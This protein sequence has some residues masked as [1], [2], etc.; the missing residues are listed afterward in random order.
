MTSVEVVGHHRGSHRY[1]RMIVGN[2]RLTDFRAELVYS[3]YVISQL[4]EV[5]VDAHNGS[6]GSAEV[7]AEVEKAVAHLIG[8]S[9]PMSD[10]MR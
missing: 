3:P 7:K 8:L 10:P 5:R 4:P 2:D 9:D 1:V 6:G